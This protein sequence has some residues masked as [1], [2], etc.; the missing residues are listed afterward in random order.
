MPNLTVNFNFVHLLTRLDVTNEKAQEE[1]GEDQVLR[2]YTGDK[3]LQYPPDN[4]TPEALRSPSMCFDAGGPT[5]KGTWVTTLN[6]ETILE[7][8]KFLLYFAFCKVLD[9]LQKIFKIVSYLDEL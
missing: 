6:G 7:E 2:L 5:K 9:Q 3:N 1:E 4:I 8:N